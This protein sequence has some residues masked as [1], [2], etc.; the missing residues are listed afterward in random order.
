MN[1]TIIVL[2]MMVVMFGGVYF[3]ALHTKSG[4]KFLGMDEPE[5]ENKELKK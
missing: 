4:H 3:W 2:L 5:K 1:D